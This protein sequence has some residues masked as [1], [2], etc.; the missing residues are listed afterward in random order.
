MDRRNPKKESAFFRQPS[1][2]FRVVDI[3]LKRILSFFF[4]WRYRYAFPDSPPSPC[5]NRHHL[6]WASVSLIYFTFFVLSPTTFTIYISTAHSAFSILSHIT[7]TQLLCLWGLGYILF[8]FSVSSSLKNLRNAL[9]FATI[10]VQEKEN[11]K[12]EEEEKNRCKVHDSFKR[13]E[14]GLICI[15]YTV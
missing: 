6:I 13:K 3:K 7:V 8:T 12:K 10:L 15:L 11:E 9:A 2:S 1:Q 4:T 14:S 5:I